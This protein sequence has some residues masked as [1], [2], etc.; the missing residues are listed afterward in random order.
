M[1]FYWL[2]CLQVGHVWLYDTVHPVAATTSSATVSRCRSEA[3]VK[4]CVFRDVQLAWA[5]QWICFVLMG[6]HVCV[7]TCVRVRVCVYSVNIQTL[8]RL[9]M[10]AIEWKWCHTLHI[11]I[12]LFHNYVP[13]S[14]LS[15][16]STWRRTNGRIRT[17][18][19]AINSYDI[20]STLQALGM[21]KYWK[22]K[23]IIL[24]K[25][26]SST[27]LNGCCVHACARARVRVWCAGIFN[28][29]CIAA[30]LKRRRNDG[31]LWRYDHEFSGRACHWHCI[32]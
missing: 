24:K 1:F 28:C 3:R 14:L 32:W 27:V 18:E 5:H 15:M 12:I 20:V 26:V 4:I 11:L 29:D 22:G 31:V 21:M 23:H 19:M 13:F 25:Q 17:Q 7:C 10:P 9:L 2:T 30:T 6:V 8:L 16:T